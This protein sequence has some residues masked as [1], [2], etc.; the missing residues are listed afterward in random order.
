METLAE[1]PELF[2]HKTSLG[3]ASFHPP[4]GVHGSPCSAACKCVRVTYPAAVKK[5]FLSRVLRW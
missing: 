3:V 2:I 4:S 1:S 5:A